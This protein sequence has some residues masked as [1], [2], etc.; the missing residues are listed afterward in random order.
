MT[1]IFWVKRAAPIINRVCCVHSSVKRVCQWAKKVFWRPLVLSNRSHAHVSQNSFDEQRAT[2]WIQTVLTKQHS[3][4]QAEAEQVD[5]PALA[6]SHRVLAF[7]LPQFH[8]FIQNDRWWGKGFTEWTNVTKATPQFIGHEQ[9]KLPADLGFYDLANPALMAEQAALAKQYGIDGFC[10]YF[11][12]FAGQTLME[13]PWQNWLKNPELDFPLCLCWANENWTRR[14]DGQDNEVLIAQ[15]HSAEDD[16][17][18]IQH[19]APYLLDSRYLKVEGKSILVLYYPSLLPNV[20]ATGE[21]WRTYMR[22]HHQQE[23]HLLC[24]QSRDM[25][26]PSS[27][28][29]DGA[30][31]F[32]PVGIHAV[33]A[34]D[35][36]ESIYGDVESSVYDYEKTLDHRLQQTSRPT[37][38]RARGV[39][40]GWDN[41][42]RRNK[43]ANLFINNT[44]ELFSHWLHDAIRD[45]RWHYQ[46]EQQLV[47]IN[48]WN[49]WAEGAYL[50]LD[51]RFGHAYLKATQKATQHW[52]Q[53]CCELLAEGEQAHSI[54]VIIHA[55]YPEVLVDIEQLMRQADL[56]A[57]IWVSVANQEA[58]SVVQAHLP[59]ARVYITPNIGRDIAPFLSLYPLM[60]A[61]NYQAILKIHTK[62]SLHRVDGDA[63]RNY[64]YQQLLPAG[65]LTE[66]L[67]AFI[68]DPRL[69]IVTPDGHAPAIKHFWGSNRSWL[70]KIAQRLSLPSATGDEP[71]TASSMFWFKPEALEALSC[72]LLDCHDF[73]YDRQH[74]IDGTLAHALER[75]F[76]WIA[77]H[78]GYETKEM[79]YIMQHNTA[80]G[81]NSWSSYLG[82]GG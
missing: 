43:Q 32:P 35:D 15:S 22:E 30:I 78:Q 38:Y 14:W 13:A 58:L 74:Q 34:S 9:P 41:T 80:Y 62:K 79:S 44:P 53:S 21:R 6:H 63:W 82:I 39:M 1:I 12:W 42:A 47:F 64:L 10:V 66:M 68:A 77:L 8:R 18:F 23:L 65:L 7:Y 5:Q 45:M 61:Y 46:G 2:H 26:D 81:Q 76:S 24:V 59:K 17:A 70:D 33:A 71:F 51:R 75:S 31:E 29:F 72:S 56:N 28:G 54:A 49:E 3:L 19:I 27:I 37:Y 60:R 50:E 25:V 11:Y 36:I 48:A 20:K 16:L 52:N 69:G 4:W 67:T 57:D 73:Y 55:Y 40:P